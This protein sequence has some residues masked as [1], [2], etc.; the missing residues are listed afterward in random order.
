[1]REVEWML[2]AVEGRGSV[3]VEDDRALTVEGRELA[4]GWEEEVVGLRDWEEKGSAR[5]DHL[6]EARLV[7]ESLVAELLFVVS[8]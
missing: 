1:V 4:V 7:R 2:V 8:G 6:Y 3:G 5:K